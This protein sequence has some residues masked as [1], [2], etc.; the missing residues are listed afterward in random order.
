MT[1]FRREDLPTPIGTICVVSKDE[2]VVALDYEGYEQRMHRLLSRYWGAYTL[3]QAD[4][5]SQAL[6]M[7]TEY[8]R[9]DLAAIV[10]I[11]TALGGS[12][13]QNAV[14]EQLR[15]IPAGSARTYGELAAELGKPSAARAVGAANALNPIAIIHPCH[16]VVG[17][18]GKLTGYAGGL[19]RKRWLLDH[20]L[21]HSGPVSGPLFA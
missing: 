8:F 11:Q 7:L 6:R 16:R 21:A 9:G 12:C 4:E 14:W 13:F 19:D 18:G 17:C 1:V 20:E 10:E 5:P 3:T 15:R 2:M